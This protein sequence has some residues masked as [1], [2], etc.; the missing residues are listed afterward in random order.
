M[1]VTFPWPQWQKQLPHAAPWRTGDCG[2]AQTM[3]VP[4]SGCTQ[5]MSYWMSFS[6]CPTSALVVADSTHA[7]LGECTGGRAHQAFLSNKVDNPSEPGVEI[8]RML[9]LLLPLGGVCPGE[10]LGLLGMVALG[11]DISVLLSDKS[12]HWLVKKINTAF[13]WYF[14]HRWVDGL[15]HLLPCPLPT[16]LLS[17]CFSCFRVEHLITSQ[18]DDTKRG[19]TTLSPSNHVP[20]DWMLASAIKQGR[21]S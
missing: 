18:G 10:V 6:L 13:P 2:L 8:A 20:G 7:L 1:F 14:L 12:V 15:S 11:I 17:V 5:S 21:I 9:P 3:K 19:S 16:I 4:L